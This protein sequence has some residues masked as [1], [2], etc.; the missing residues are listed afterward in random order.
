MSHFIDLNP[1]QRRESIN[2]QQRYAALR[3]AAR[4][5]SFRGSMVWSQV[6]G[7]DY[8][9]RS[10]YTA[11]GERKQT[12]LGPR[13]PET[14]KL[15]AEYDRGRAEAAQ[16]LADI[17]STL[18]RQAAV[19]RALALGRVPQLG[20]RIIRALDEAEL[21]GASLRILGTYSLFAY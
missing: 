19:N 14:E 5:K 18:D 1:D 20:A 12:S 21:L 6:K 10:A 8:L 9:I 2:T 7:R 11:K 4:A 17:R 13:S 3:A 16:R 15:K